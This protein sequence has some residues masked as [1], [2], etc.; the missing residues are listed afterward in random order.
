MYVQYIFRSV[1][2]Q[3]L[4]HTY[5]GQ[6]LGCKYI[7]YMMSLHTHDIILLSSWLVVDATAKDAD[8]EELGLEKLPIVLS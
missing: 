1:G 6:I 2:Y 7:I 4:Q 8:H 3:S 5:L